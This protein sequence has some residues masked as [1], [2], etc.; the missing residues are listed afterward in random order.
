MGCFN[1]LKMKFRKG[2]TE[3]ERET[4]RVREVR[5]LRSLRSRG[6]VSGQVIKMV[7]KVSGVMSIR[8]K[9]GTGRV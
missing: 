5:K 8:V 2:E 7:K 3:G 6:S 4:G 1:V 9:G